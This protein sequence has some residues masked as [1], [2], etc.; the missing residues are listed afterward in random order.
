MSEYKYKASTKSIVRFVPACTRLKVTSPKDGM[1]VPR[2]ADLIGG[3]IY[4]APNA[5]ASSGDGDKM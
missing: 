3:L 4:P 5:L 2:A 1:A